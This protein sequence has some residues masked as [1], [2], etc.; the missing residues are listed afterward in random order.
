VASMLSRAGLWLSVSRLEGPE[1]IRSE[2]LE[3]AVALD[4]GGTAPRRQ[5]ADFLDA[6][7]SEE[8][9]GQSSLEHLH[10]RDL[11]RRTEA[12]LAEVRRELQQLE[13]LPRAREQDKME[14]RTLREQAMRLE[15]QCADDKRSFSGEQE[16]LKSLAV[17]CVQ[18]LGRCLTEGSTDNL[19]KIACRFLSLWFDYSREYPEVTASVQ[20]AIPRIALGPLTPFIYQLASRLDMQEGPFQQTL[21]ELLVRIVVRCTQALWPL[22][23]LRNGDSVPKG[24]RGAERFRP[25]TAKITA[26]KRVLDRLRKQPAVKPVLEAVEVLSRFY[27]DVAFHAVDKR[28][29]ETEV[30]VSSIQTFRDV[31][32]VLQTAR[33]PVPT[34]PLSPDGGPVPLIGSFAESFGIAKQGVSA[35]KVL[36]VRDTAG[37]EHPQIVKGMDDL[38]QDAVMQQL[39]RLLNDVFAE[40]ALSRQANLRL[41]TFQV[42]PLSPCAGIVEWVTET[43]TVGEML[44]GNTVPAEGSH[45]RYRSHDW[46][47]HACRKHMQEARE[48]FNAGNAGILES[49]LLEVYDHFKPVMHLAFLERYPSPTD[50]HRARQHYARSAAVSSIVGYIVGIGDR[51]PNNILFD[52]KTGELVHI[53]FGITFEAG[54]ALRVPELVPFRLTRD[55]VDGLGC[56]GTCGLFRHCCETAMEVL[57]GSAALVVAVAEVFVH[58]PVYFW[59]LSPRKARQHDAAPS[60]DQGAGNALEALSVARALAGSDGNEMARRAL[61]AVKGKLHGTHESTAALGVPA[62][63]GWVIHEAVDV[64][65]LARMY[66]G[67]SPW[68]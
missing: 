59:S 30:P 52:Y 6:R 23:L 46:S 34:A 29:R 3:P 56:L 20:E 47:H 64:A 1:A 37:K 12:E 45:H 24:M 43:L 68:L 67:W 7:L 21:D 63:V 8:L 51:H 48:A 25:D 36:K 32:K 18:H 50:W 44:T 41:R 33:V 22:V 17:N 14:M 16:R 62:H 11:H 15:K 53:D 26:A 66:F 9:A 55:M 40:N 42:V 19:T 31:R 5:L 54:R 28:N 35:P 57:R 58:D 61:L 10:R 60:A 65:N 4:P 27:L 39:F 13:R 38:R 49:A 2:Y